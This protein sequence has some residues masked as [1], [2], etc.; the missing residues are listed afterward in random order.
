MNRIPQKQAV[1]KKRG[2]TV[3][4]DPQQPASTEAKR[5]AAAILEVLAGARTPTDAATVLTISL[6][7]YYHL[8]Q[9][10]LGGLVAACEPRGKG[11]RPSSQKRADALQRQVDVLQRETARQQ[12]LLRAAQRTIGLAPPSVPKKVPTTAGSRKK[13]QRRPTARALAAAK[14]LQTALD[15]SASGEQTMAPKDA[16]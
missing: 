14:S 1:G 8:E 13:R 9:R 16:P 4:Q 7:R 15:R 5:L 12:A 10:A 6:P 11:P 2:L 3:Q